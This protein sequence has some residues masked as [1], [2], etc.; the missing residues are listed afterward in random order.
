MANDKYIKCARIIKGL[1]ALNHLVVNIRFNYNILLSIYNQRKKIK[2][3]EYKN[4]E[5]AFNN[6][7]LV[8]SII[9]QYIKAYE[10]ELDSSFLK[11]KKY[12]KNKAYLFENEWYL[13]LLGL[14]N[15]LQ[16]VFHFKICFGNFLSNKEEDDD[17][18]IANYTLLN[19]EDLHKNKPENIAMLRYFKYCWALPIMDFS[20]NI[21][22]LIE[23]F[24]I[25]YNKTIHEHYNSLLSKYDNDKN[26]DQ[27]ATNLHD[28][29]LNNINSFKNIED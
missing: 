14:R 5:C 20:T 22:L 10:R 24:Q 23:N 16:H 6:F 12:V 3:I 21:L 17:L 25:K 26:N 15:Y 4:V 9:K 8:S 28:I 27:Y 19:H 1:N 2:D 18:F 13:I 29:Y 11:T 7:I